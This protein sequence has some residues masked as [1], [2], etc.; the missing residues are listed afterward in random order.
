MKQFVE[1]IKGLEGDEVFKV[2][3]LYAEKVLKLAAG[4]TAIL[5][6]GRMVGPLGE[7][8][9]LTSNDF[10]L[11]EKLT[12]SQYGEKLVQAFHNHL[13]VQRSDISDIALVTG[14]LL[15]SRS[16]SSKA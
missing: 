6:N 8:D 10:D 12:M 11:L 4:Q 16:S 3:R 7:K 13:D 5:V 1:K 14:G 15:T 2:H 9:A